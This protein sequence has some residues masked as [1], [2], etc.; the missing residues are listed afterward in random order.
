[1]WQ[2]LAGETKYVM[3]IIHFN[4]VLLVQPTTVIE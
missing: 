1:M 3:C 4:I 2:D